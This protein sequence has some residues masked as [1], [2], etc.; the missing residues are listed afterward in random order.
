MPV[1]I[2]YFTVK[3]K[4]RKLVVLYLWEMTELGDDKE[5]DQH[6]QNDQKRCDEALLVKLCLLFVSYI[7]A[8]LPL[9]NSCLGVPGRFY[10]FTGRTARETRIG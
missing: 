7:G 4:E 3:P 1:V 8:S 2:G 10:F 9:P 6:D 5:T